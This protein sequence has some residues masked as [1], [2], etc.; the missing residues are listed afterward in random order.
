LEVERVWPPVAESSHGQ[1]ARQEA[2]RPDDRLLA[3]GDIPFHRIRLSD[4][5]CPEIDVEAGLDELP[6]NRTAAR[7]IQG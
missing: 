6:R 4:S 7:P 2:F 5:Q 1:A 3:D